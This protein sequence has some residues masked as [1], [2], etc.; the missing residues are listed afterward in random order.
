MDKI[1]HKTFVPKA[2]ESLKLKSYGSIAEDVRREA[3]AYIDRIGADK[4]LTI[5]ENTLHDEFAVVVW[6]YATS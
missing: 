5:T 1:I 2:L 6:H 3:E 4:V